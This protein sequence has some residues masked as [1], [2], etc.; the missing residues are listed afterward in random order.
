MPFIMRSIQRLHSMK[1]A[2]SAMNSCYWVIVGNSVT[3]YTFVEVHAQPWRLNHFTWFQKCCV[4]TV[5]V[6]DILGKLSCMLE[7][8]M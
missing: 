8:Q 7:A 6:S 3:S 1:H 2:M 5:I 4:L